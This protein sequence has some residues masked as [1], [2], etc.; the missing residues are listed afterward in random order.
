MRE[1]G[2]FEAKTHL[3]QLLDAVEKGERVLITRHGRPAALLV[4]PA[5]VRCGTVAQ[6]AARMRALRAQTRPG[7][8]S[9]KDLV[10]EGRRF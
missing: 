5:G 4:P 9:L 3:A 7:A 6:V 1:V 2:S 10:E 8:E